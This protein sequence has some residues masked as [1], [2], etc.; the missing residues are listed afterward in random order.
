MGPDLV[1]FSELCHQFLKVAPTLP[2]SA[3]PQKLSKRD[4]YFGGPEF[5]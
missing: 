1:D 4:E 5:D 2:G 3:T